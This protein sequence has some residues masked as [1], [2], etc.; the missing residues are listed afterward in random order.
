MCGICGEIR[1][2]DQAPSTEAVARMREVMVPRGPD[3][4]GLFQAG[5]IAT[6][7]PLGATGAVLTVK[8]L[9]ELARREAKRGVVTMCIGGGQ[10]IA[11]IL[12]K[13]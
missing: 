13:A 11:T 9:G 10:G 4:A 7:H 8:L 3:G 2:D 6:G 1:F 12:E 5:A